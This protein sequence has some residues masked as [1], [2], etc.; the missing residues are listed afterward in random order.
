VRAALGL[1]LGPGPAVPGSTEPAEAA[2]AEAG[3]SGS[4]L[5]QQTSTAQWPR[6]LIRP[7][8]RRPL[9]KARQGC[10]APLPAPAAA[11][12]LLRLRRRPVCRRA[13]LQGVLRLP[14]RA[15]LRSAV[16]GWALGQAQAE[17]R[18]VG[19]RAEGYGGA[20]PGGVGGGGGHH[21]GCACYPFMSCESELAVLSVEF[22]RSE[23]PVWLVHHGCLRRLH[24]GAAL[25]LF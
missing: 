6:L 19:R 24:A 1:E 23:C 2:P 16:P 22:L 10:A 5:Q 21:Q 8:G 12:D 14:L 13:P 4:S 25:D 9:A 7:Q 11:Q 17:L 3:A 20:G 15:L 18:G